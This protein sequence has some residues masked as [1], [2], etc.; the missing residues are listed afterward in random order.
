[1]KFEHDYKTEDGLFLVQIDMNKLIYEPLQ[2]EPNWVAKNI[3]CNLIDVYNTYTYAVSNKS[4]YID[5]NGRLYFKGKKSSWHKVN[6][7]YI[8]EL[9]FVGVSDEQTQNLL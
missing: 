9:V 4:L 5:K 1:M 2:A 6:K 7:Y 8:D 3:T